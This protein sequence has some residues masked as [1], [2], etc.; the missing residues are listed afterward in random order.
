M[1]GDITFRPCVEFGNLL[2][3]LRQ[4]TDRT[5]NYIPSRLLGPVSLEY[6]R[7]LANVTSSPHDIEM[8]ALLQLFPKC[9][10]RKV[11][12]GSKMKQA[13]WTRQLLA[14]WLAGDDG[15]RQLIYQ[16]LT[17]PEAQVG[18]VARDQKEVNLRRCKHMVRCNRLSSA[19]RALTS[20][21]VAPISSAVLDTLMEKHPGRAMA[22]E[23]PLPAPHY[24]TVDFKDVV[25]A[26]HTF[27][28]GS[29]CG[30][31]G[32]R[33]DYLVSMYT[34]KN[35]EAKAKFASYLT[36]LVNLLLS[37]GMPKDLAPFVA[38][39]PITALSKP[40]GGIRPIAVG[41]VIRRLVSKVAV[42][43]VLEEA[44]NILNPLQ[45][46]VASKRGLETAIFDL[47]HVLRTYGDDS[48]KCA[49]LFDFQ[50]AF[51]LI[52][53]Q[54]IFDRVRA[55]LPGISKWVEYCYEQEALLFA[56]DHT[57][58]SSCG[59]QQG[60][61]LGPLLFAI[62]LHPL[63]T[64]IDEECPELDLNRWYLDDGTV[65]GPKKRCNNPRIS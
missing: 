39:A 9:V 41:E 34:V 28:K 48:S 24:I 47:E 58:M 64:K 31:D 8:H 4:S 14:T 6:T 51:N 60:D 13:Q 40:D 35:H 43:G 61:P 26:L 62:A 27:A 30:R 57:L 10:L 33:A 11:S 46:G 19:A 15:K 56:D 42:D 45:V 59:V 63:I 5:I 17:L 16:M 22:L 37:G 29:A 3:R 2:L 23:C 20:S 25:R 18:T 38:S 55:S 54:V 32:L 44:L 49:L 65:A 53:R 36:K 50:N 7:L 21:G 52:D 12:G 1:A